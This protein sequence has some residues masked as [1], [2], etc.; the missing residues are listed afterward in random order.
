MRS[1]ERITGPVS[2]ASDFL[3]I[4]GE[5]VPRT[6][7]EHDLVRLLIGRHDG[8]RRIRQL[9]VDRLPHPWLHDHEDDQQHEQNVDHRHD[10]RLGAESAR[11][12]AC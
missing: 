6:D 3:F 12:V 1:R 8:R 7:L 2:P 5:L 9:Q 11:A 4:D 10:V